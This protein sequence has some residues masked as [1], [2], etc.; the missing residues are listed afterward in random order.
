MTTVAMNFHKIFKIQDNI[1]LGLSGLAT[2]VLTLHA[3]LK[4]R[5][6]LFNLRQN[7]KIKPT[8]FC[9]LLASVLYERRW[10]PFYTSPIVCGLEN[11]KPIIGHFDLIG[12]LSIGD[13][14]ETAGSAENMLK[15]VAETFY[16]KDMD[17]E[18]L[19]EMTA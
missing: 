11:G 1:L 13:T 3:Y 7:T 2:D 16:K 12:C 5:V 10:S 19:E 14:F 18:T 8:T 15:G 9:H 17:S 6:N 4:V